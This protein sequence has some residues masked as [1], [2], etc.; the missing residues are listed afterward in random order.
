MNDIQTR[1]DIEILIDKFYKKVIIDDVI[2]DF[3]TETVQLD[4]T[5][6][7]PIMYDFWE[8]TLLSAGKYKGNPMIKHIDLSEKKQLKAEHFERW[9]KLWEETINEHFKG[10]KSE[11][12]IMRAKQIGGLMNHKI[13]QHSQGHQ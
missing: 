8:S 3:F 6:H 13:Q 2:G 9:L 5:V 11:E 1:Q 7:I 4:W 10:K 12:A